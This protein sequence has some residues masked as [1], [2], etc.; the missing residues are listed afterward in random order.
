MIYNLHLRHW[1][2]S[3]ERLL[4]WELQNGQVSMVFKVACSPL[5]W[6]PFMTSTALF[7]NEMPI[8]LVYNISPTARIAVTNAPTATRVP[9][10]PHKFERYCCMKTLWTYSSYSHRASSTLTTDWA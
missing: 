10:D 5:A 7:D 4:N 2:L 3:F 6:A 1:N 9:I 8:F